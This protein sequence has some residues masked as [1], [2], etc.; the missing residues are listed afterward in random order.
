MSNCPLEAWALVHPLRAAEPTSTERAVLW[1]HPKKL[2][3]VSQK[4]QES[5]SAFPSAQCAG[6]QSCW[7]HLEQD[8]STRV[9]EGTALSR[10]AVCKVSKSFSSQ[11]SCPPSKQGNKTSFALTFYEKCLFSCWLVL[12]CVWL[13]CFL[14][15]RRYAKKPLSLSQNSSVI[16]S[17]HFSTPAI[18]LSREK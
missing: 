6:V 2:E 15:G 10:E 18:L 17:S 3:V 14:R 4:P 16:S 13:S 5:L 11:G 7:S 12:L 9:G 8:S 1:H